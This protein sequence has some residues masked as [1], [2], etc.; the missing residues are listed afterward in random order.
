MFLRLQLLA[1]D[2][3]EAGLAIPDGILT[4]PELVDA[5]SRPGDSR[6]ERLETAGA[7]PKKKRKNCTGERI[8]KTGTRRIYL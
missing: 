8:Y 7:Y 2:L 1:Y 5:L 4:I 3:K 6:T